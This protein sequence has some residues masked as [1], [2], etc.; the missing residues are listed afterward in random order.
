MKSA[1]G[2]ASAFP[3]LEQAALAALVE[4]AKKGKQ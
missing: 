2:A 3:Q 1:E 4:F